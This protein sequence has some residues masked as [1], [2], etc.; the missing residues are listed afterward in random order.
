MKMMARFGR[1][2]NVNSF[3]DISQTA[4]TLI[5]TASPD[6]KDP[7]WNAGSEKI[8]RILLQCLHNTKTPEHKHLASLKHLLA[9][10]DLT[11][12]TPQSLTAMD[13]FILDNT[14]NDPAL[15]QEYRSFLAGN[16]KTMQAILMSAEVALNAIGNPDLATLTSQNT[17]DFSQLKKR[18]TAIFILAKQQDLSYFEFLLN[19]FYTDL[20]RTLLSSYDPSHLPVYLL[21][22]EFGHLQ[23]NNFDV[24]ITTARKYKIGIWIFLQSLSQLESRYGTAKART[25]LDGLQTEIYLPGQN[26][27][28]AQRLAQRLGQNGRGGRPLM[29]ADQIIS[30]K[31]KEALFFYSNYR[32]LKVRTK[33]YYKQFAMRRKSNLPAAELPHSSLKP[34]SLVQM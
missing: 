14:Q 1:L 29:S 7:F 13:R 21:L 4:H 24:V 32:P 3:T 17:L 12:S 6:A 23:L 28:V 9:N 27:D 31:D 26:L 10:F 15:F 2:H 5:Q 30:M 33:P 20:F 18:K 19:L 11:P 22:D 16:Q 34:P 25:I 8:L